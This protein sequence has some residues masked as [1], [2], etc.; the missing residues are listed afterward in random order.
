MQPH[1]PSSAKRRPTQKPILTPP[2]HPAGPSMGYHESNPRPPGRQDK[3]PRRHSP[4]CHSP[5]G[6]GATTGTGS[7]AHPRS[8]AHYRHRRRQ[9]I[10]RFF[11]LLSL[12]VSCLVV[13]FNL[14]HWPA[15]LFYGVQASP[16]VQAALSQT[17]QFQ[18]V[19][20]VGNPELTPRELAQTAQRLEQHFYNKLL[21]SQA[22]TLDSPISAE[23]LLPLMPVREDVALKQSL[24]SLFS[25]YP[26]SFKPHVYFFDPQRDVAVSLGGET[27]VSAA[28]VIKLPVLYATFRAMENGLIA[29][30][31]MIPY[32]E[33]H[34]AGGAGGL[35]YQPAG[36]AIPALEVARQMI[37]LSDNTC[38][39]ILID[40]LGGNDRLNRLFKH[41]G[42]EQTRIAEWLP[43]LPGDNVISMRD[44]ATLLYNVQLGANLSVE[45]RSAMVHIL[46]G[47]HNRRLIPALLPAETLVAHK[48]G[49]IGTSLGNAAIVYL[50]DGRYYILAI[51]VERPYNDYTAKPM[52]QRASRLVFDHMQQMPTETLADVASGGGGSSVRTPQ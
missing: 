22:L 51:Q 24:E 4:G 39:N 52:I 25:Q 45:A 20:G 1:G 15:Q 13:L 28:S 23:R 21:L 40:Q 46:L 27:P 26:A 29:P 30:E 5:R 49:D 8:A 36:Q 41:M 33:H 9:Q 7:S 43:D 48:T 50:P 31:S 32:L 10:M 6:N 44:M 16:V 38:T 11:I 35:Q 3:P 42:L 14:R 18:R 12:A 19:L 47:T 34:R 37:Q 17:S 2:R